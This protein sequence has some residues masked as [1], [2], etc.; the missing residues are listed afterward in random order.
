MVANRFIPRQTAFQAA[1]ACFVA[2]ALVPLASAAPATHGSLT[3]IQTLPPDTAL[4]AIGPEGRTVYT[5]G[6]S[7][8]R[9]HAYRR[10][11]R[12]GRL[13]LL[14]RKAGCLARTDPHCSRGGA[15]NGPTALVASAHTVLLASWTGRQHVALYRRS[16]TGALRLTSC[17][18]EVTEGVACSPGGRRT[19]G[20]LAVSPDGRFGYLA[21]REGPKKVT[22]FAIENGG[23]SLREVGCIGRAGSTAC[24]P[25][26][27]RRLNPTALAVSA[28]GR[29]LYVASSTVTEHGVVFAFARNAQTGLVTPLAG[30]TGC[31]AASVGTCGTLHEIS[32]YGPG[33]GQPG[34]AMAVSSDGRLVVVGGFAPVSLQKGLVLA[35]ARD[36]ATGALTQ[37]GCL[38]VS[39]GC[40]GNLEAVLSLA[41]APDARTVYAGTFNELVV[42]RRSGQALTQLARAPIG[43]T[44]GIV[45]SRDG[46][47]VY[48]ADGRLVVFRVQR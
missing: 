14:P 1:F 6:G 2:I 29:N 18:G 22:I 13:T 21:A 37:D 23:S 26:R 46:R 12:T 19:T 42:I 15:I 11:S 47:S 7:S 45:A 5:A 17:L 43:R 30:Q 27:T 3:R 10:A 44:D 40:A 36:P 33:E 31:L 8:D 20:A 25:V 48:A 9:M 16:A 38:G 28:D 35:L 34:G 41:L 24:T 39:A 4:V 32:F